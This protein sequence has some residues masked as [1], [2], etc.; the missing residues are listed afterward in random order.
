M[1][2]RIVDD[3]RRGD[4]LQPPSARR[5]AAGRPHFLCRS[6]SPMAEHRLVVASR[7]RGR[8]ARNNSQRITG[9]GHLAAGRDTMSPCPAAV[10]RQL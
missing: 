8:R 5:V 4:R 2:V 10:L 7:N 9:T 1:P 6:S 3:E